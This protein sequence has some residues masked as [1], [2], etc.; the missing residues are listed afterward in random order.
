M[1]ALRTLHEMTLYSD[2]APSL[3]EILCHDDPHTKLPPLLLKEVLD[4]AMNPLE[5]G[6]IHFQSKYASRVLAQSGQSTNLTLVGC[7]FEPVA[8]EAFVD[9]MLSKMDKNNGLT[10]LTF[11]IICHSILIRIWC[12]C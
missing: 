8:K 10:K 9:G 5:F 4:K 3:E 1:E 7:A 12:V 2:F 11:W 6:N